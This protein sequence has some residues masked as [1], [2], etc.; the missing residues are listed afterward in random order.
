MSYVESFS[1]SLMEGI[2]YLP[3]AK[4]KVISILSLT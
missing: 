2:A 3:A 4:E 1:G